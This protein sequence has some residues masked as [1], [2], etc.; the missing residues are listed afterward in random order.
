VK[1]PFQSRSLSEQLVADGLISRDAGARPQESDRQFFMRLQQEGLIDS[2]RLFTVLAARTD[3]LPY[4]IDVVCLDQTGI[5][6]GLS[7]FFSSVG[8]W[9]HQEVTAEMRVKADQALKML[10]EATYQ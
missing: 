7:G 6:S 3:M 5:V 8:I 10:T 2:E 1:N 9:P 4:S